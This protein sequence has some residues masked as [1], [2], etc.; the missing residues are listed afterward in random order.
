MV[1]MVATS[2]KKAVT[3]PEMLTLLGSSSQNT[4]VAQVAVGDADVVE[5][6]EMG[7]ED[8]SQVESVVRCESL[9]VPVDELG[10]AYLSCRELVQLAEVR[11][12][13]VSGWVGEWL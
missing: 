3:H 6:C 13:V 8:F 9:C 12:H 5:A 11:V 4:V 7:D 10:E 2:G 1:P